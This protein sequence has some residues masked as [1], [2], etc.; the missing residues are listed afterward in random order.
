MVSFVGSL[1][2]VPGVRFAARG[3]D[4]AWAFVRAWRVFIEQRQ[5]IQVARPHALPLAP[6]AVEF[7]KIPIEEDPTSGQS[8]EHVHA[9]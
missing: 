4:L 2:A 8:V 9:V 5:E 1:A 6:V 7:G 3:G